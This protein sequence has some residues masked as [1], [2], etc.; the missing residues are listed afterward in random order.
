LPER[1]EHRVTGRA[2]TAGLGLQHRLGDQA[3]QRLRDVPAVEVVATGDRYRGRRVEGAR[4]HTEPVE[5]QAFVVL[6][7]LVGPFDRRP[8]RLVPFHAAAAL[9]GEQPEAL[10]EVRRDVGRAH[11]RRARR[12]ELDGERDAVDS[13]AD[14]A[15]RRPLL[16]VPR[17]I[18][19]GVCRTV[20][21]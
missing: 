4:E 12:S 6:E 11:R 21:K 16:R 15:D 3:R 14:L 18:G 10:V 8:Q 20:G 19:T 5:H 2:I 13:A 17:R 9:A 7:K 1:F